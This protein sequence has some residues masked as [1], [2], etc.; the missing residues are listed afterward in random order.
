MKIGHKLGV[1]FGILVLLTL[2][3]AGLGY[4]SSEKAAAQIERTRKFQLPLVL[5]LTEAETHLFEMLSGVRGYL[6][7]GLEKYRD[8]YQAAGDAFQSNLILMEQL[9]KDCTIDGHGDK[10]KALKAAYHEWSKL[11]KELFHIRDDQLERE[12]ALRMMMQ[13]VQPALLFIIRDIRK[14]MRG[15]R[16]MEPR[17]ELFLLI[18]DVAG[19]QSSLYSMIAGL[20]AY[21][22]TGRDSFKFEYHANL[23]MNSEFLERMMRKKS[24]FLPAQRDLLESIEKNRAR[25]LTY[26]D[27]IF[28]IVEGDAVRKDLFIYKTR[29]LPFA[30]QMLKNLSDLVKSHETNLQN[31]LEESSEKLAA[32]RRQTFSGGALAIL[33]GIC[34][35][36]LLAGNF[37]GPIRRLIEVTRKIREGDF[38]VRA[39]VESNDEIGR[40]AGTFN[41]MAEKLQ[42]TME[43]LKQAKEAAEAASRAKSAFLA[44]ISHELRTPLNA[45]IGYSELMEMNSALSEDEKKNMKSIRSSGEHLLTLINQV[46]DMSA[47]EHGALPLE[48]HE[49][50][51]CRLLRDVLD[52]FRMKT[53]KKGLALQMTC[54]PDLPEWILTDSMRLRQI[55]INMLGNAVKFTESGSVSLHVS[56]ISQSLSQDLQAICEEGEMKK[57]TT[58]L[59]TKK[60]ENLEIET[61]DIKSKASKKSVLR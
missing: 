18:E 10:L 36:F 50:D 3:V 48:M 46:L 37:A 27:V 14:V 32:A 7:L 40:L 33:F 12:P 53:V 8:D 20:R 28:D 54:S 51:L 42:I 23:E 49:T 38:S 43:D 24:T 9:K 17:H 55:L 26:P 61:T 35:S 4:V 58:D 6:A 13:E 5:T 39:V 41:R 19:F 59:E 47:I 31:E 1:S 30:E 22:T 25:S 44:N 21:I 60:I 16:E 57:K 45:V 15:F 56:I 29:A 11:P 34:L 52:M 2:M